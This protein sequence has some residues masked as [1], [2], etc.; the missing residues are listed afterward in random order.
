[1]ENNTKLTN[2]MYSTFLRRHSRTAFIVIRVCYGILIGCGLI[3][4]LLDIIEKS[5]E[6]LGSVIY[7]FLMA[8]LFILYDIF[9]VKIHLLLVKDKT[10]I[11]CNYKFVLNE[12]NLDLTI[13]KG[14]TELSKSTLSYSTINKVMFYED[15]IYIYI[16]K[17]SAYILDK[18]G[19][20]SEEDY[21][22]A[23]KILLPYQ[24]NAKK[25][26]DNN[27]KTK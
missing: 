6:G 26:T 11:D 21:K 25:K 9:F 16:N 10:I 18:N 8:I 19:F 13:T 24:K 12:N 5:H 3:S 17:I 14:D 7:C 15:T 27:Q 4:L 20:A 1:M 2:K 23:V 22:N